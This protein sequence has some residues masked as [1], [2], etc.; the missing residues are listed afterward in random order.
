MY[1]NEYFENFYVRYKAEKLPRNI[2]VREFCI[3]NKDSME[4]VRQ[5]V[6]RFMI[7]SQASLCDWHA[8][9]FGMT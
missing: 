7:P 9:S 4:S 2:S 8:G 6:P 5:M 3:R 1:S